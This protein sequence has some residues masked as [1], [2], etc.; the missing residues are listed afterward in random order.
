MTYLHAGQ[1][2]FA[3]NWKGHDINAVIHQLS[4]W[5]WTLPTL[6]LS[7]LIIFIAKL[8]MVVSV[9]TLVLTLFIAFR[10]FLKQEAFFVLAWATL[11]AHAPMLFIFTLY[12]Q[13]R[14]D[15]MAWDMSAILSIVAIAKVLSN[16]GFSVSARSRPGENLGSE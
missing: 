15:M 3:G 6:P 4:V 2:L 10:L 9:F 11:A 8:F 13:F 16:R 7:P 1:E 12:G 5:L 14:Y